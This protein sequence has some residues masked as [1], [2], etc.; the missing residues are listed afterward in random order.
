VNCKE[1]GDEPNDNHFSFGTKWVDVNELDKEARQTQ[2]CKL[3]TGEISP[4]YRPETWEVDHLSRLVR[5][6]VRLTEHLFFD[7]SHVP[8]RGGKPMNPERE[9]VW[10]IH[11][12]YSAD[13]CKIKKNNV[14]ARSTP[15][16]SPST[17][18]PIH[19]RNKM[20][21]TVR[22]SFLNQNSVAGR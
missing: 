5:I 6:P 12:I 8:C 22:N 14:G 20:P 17:N 7:A 13:G 18:G 2:L 19:K 11:P 1:H 4:Q 15:I 21:A 9:S 10:E 16:G 3:V